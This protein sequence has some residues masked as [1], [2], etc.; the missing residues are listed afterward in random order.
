V[1]G[2]SKRLGG[3]TARLARA[4]VVVFPAHRFRKSR[5]FVENSLDG[6][7]PSK[8]DLPDRVDF[9]YTAGKSKILES[10]IAGEPGTLSQV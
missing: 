1:V 8:D 9:V 10:L 6:F 4:L 3:N 5:P 7:N 2:A